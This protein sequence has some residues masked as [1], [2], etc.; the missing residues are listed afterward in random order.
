MDRLPPPQFFRQ[1]GRLTDKETDTY[2]DGQTEKQKDR[3]ILQ[4]R[5][6]DNFQRQILFQ[7]V[8][9]KQ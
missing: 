1:M 6:T 3:Q 8:E 2:S 9:H 4:F 5:Q 7:T